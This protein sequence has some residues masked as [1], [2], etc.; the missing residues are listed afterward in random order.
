MKKSTAIY[1]F[2]GFILGM[3]AGLALLKF[4]FKVF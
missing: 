3:I 2:E 1:C 4:V